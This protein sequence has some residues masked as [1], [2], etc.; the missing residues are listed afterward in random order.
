MRNQ[1][2]KGHEHPSILSQICTNSDDWQCIQIHNSAEHYMRH[3]HSTVEVGDLRIPVHVIDCLQAGYKTCVVMSNYTDVIVTLLFC[4]PTFLQ[5]GLGNYGNRQGE[6]PQPVLCPFTFY[7]H[8]WVLMTYAQSFQHHIASHAVISPAILV[9]R[10]RPSMLKNDPLAR[11]WHND[12]TNFCN[13]STCRRVLGECCRCL[14][15]VQQFPRTSRTPIS[16]F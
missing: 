4:V 11:I 1:S 15:Q 3:L 5:K 2:S 7:M 8:G 14:E 13:N 9:Q 10:K 6:A 12:Y 16:L